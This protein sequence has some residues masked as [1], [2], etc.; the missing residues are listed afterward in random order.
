MTAGPEG[1]WNSLISGKATYLKRTPD[2]DQRYTIRDIPSSAILKYILWD[3]GHK[4]ACF[5]YLLVA[6]IEG[7]T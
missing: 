4:M 7:G 3:P 2:M 5:L 1:N 6:D